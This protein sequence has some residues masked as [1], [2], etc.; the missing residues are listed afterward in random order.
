MNILKILHELTAKRYFVPMCVNFTAQNTDRDPIGVTRATTYITSL[1]ISNP[2]PEPSL[3]ST[4]A[5]VIAAD[6]LRFVDESYKPRSQTVN[7]Y[8]KYVRGN[9]YPTHEG[10]IRDNLLAHPKPNARHL[11][12]FIEVLAYSES[13]AVKVAQEY[14]RELRLYRTDS[15]WG[16]ATRTCAINCGLYP[17]HPN[18]IKNLQ[19][20]RYI[21][22][23][24]GY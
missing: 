14:A 12:T 18:H 11:M 3:S 22:K 2:L 19:D 9:C 5:G 4:I 24:R 8:L 7:A 23:N 21:K 6:K 15:R 16:R 17:L 20:L 10:F 13:E 1:I